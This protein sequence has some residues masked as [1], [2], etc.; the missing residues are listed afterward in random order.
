[1][2]HGF[3]VHTSLLIYRE[4]GDLMIATK[5]SFENEVRGV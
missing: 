2:W 5:M 3:A 4:K 1:M